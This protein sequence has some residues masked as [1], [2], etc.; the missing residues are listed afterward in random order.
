M[1]LCNSTTRTVTPK[2]SFDSYRKTSMSFCSVFAHRTD[3]ETVKQLQSK[4]FSLCNMLQRKNINSRFV[5]FQLDFWIDVMC[6]M[7]NQLTDHCK[8]LLPQSV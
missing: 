6:D 7:P 1:Q 3:D 2:R 8:D 4:Y 5:A